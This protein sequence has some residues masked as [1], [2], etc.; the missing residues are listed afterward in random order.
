MISTLNL[1]VYISTLIR[2]NVS[3]AANQHFPKDHVT[4]KTGVMAAD[5]GNLKLLFKVEF[6]K[7]S[8]KLH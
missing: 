3:W 4:L 6:K 2:R 5:S 7:K 1:A 8:F